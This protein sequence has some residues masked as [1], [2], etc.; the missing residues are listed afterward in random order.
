VFNQSLVEASHVEINLVSFLSH[1]QH[2]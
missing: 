2:F 1:A